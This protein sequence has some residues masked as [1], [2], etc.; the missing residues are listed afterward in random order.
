MRKKR[1]LC[2]MLA[3]AALF[4]FAGCNSEETGLTIDGF[5][6]PEPITAEDTDMTKD[7]ERETM[8]YSSSLMDENLLITHNVLDYGAAANGTKNDGPAIVSAMKAAEQAGGGIVFLPAGDYLV[9]QQLTVPGNVTLCGEWIGNGEGFENGTTLLVNVGRGDNSTSSSS[10]FLRMSAGSMLSRMNIY[11]PGQNAE[12]PVAYPYT[13]ANNAYLGFTVDSVNIINPYRGIRVVNHNVITLNQINMSPIREGMYVDLIYDIPR[14]TRITMSPELWVDYAAAKGAGQ[15]TAI[16]EAVSQVVGMRFGKQDW[17]Y[18]Y[19]C[20]FSGLDTA[21]RLED[22]ENGSGN[23]NGQFYNITMSDVNYG[24]HF[25]SVASVGVSVAYADIDAKVSAVRSETGFHYPAHVF[26]NASELNAGGIAV[27]NAGDGALMFT[28][29]TFENW[30]DYAL[31]NLGMGYVNADTCTFEKDGKIAQIGSSTAASAIVNCTF[32][33]AEP[34]WDNASSSDQVYLR[35]AEVSEKIP[36]LPLEKEYSSERRSAATDMVFFASDF[37]AVADANYLNFNSATDNTEAIQRALNAAGKVGGGIVYLE[38]GDY[39]VKDYLVIP[40]GVELRGVSE[41]NRHFGV[42]KKGTTLVTGCGEGNAEGTPFISMN[43]RAGLRG[44]NVFYLNQHYSYHIAYP[45]AVYVA[46]EGCYIYDVTIPDAYTAVLVTGDDVHIDYL[47][48]LGV[49]ACLVLNGANGAFVE[50]TMITGGDWQDSESQRLLNAP[51]ADLWT[52]HPNYRNEGIYIKDSDRVTL[53]ECFVFGMASG[54]HLVGEV[55]NLVAL[56]LGVDASDNAVLLENKG[57]AVFSNTQLVGNA[58]YIHTTESFEGDASFYMTA[59]WFGSMD[60]RNTF[61]GKG[62]VRIQQY[63]V[64]NGGVDVGT[65][66]TYLQNLAFDLVTFTMLT[67][68]P[69]SE[70]YILNSVG[71]IN[72]LRTEGESENFQMINIGKR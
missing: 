28:E 43:D 49:S 42:N 70:G 4:S 20:D 56:G 2:L 40:E 50:N 69:D 6:I 32:A 53:F 11:Y 13:I 48:G 7:T 21:V 72:V 30:G 1:W 67:V 27:D 24:F 65:A 12:A 15:E 57:K 26:F 68:A 54:L 9:S 29:C 62:T 31:S 5:S 60:V 38:A 35:D 44:L 34:A 3:F 59:G 63:K 33:S 46:G 36:R 71:T 66:K 64:A 37:G 61:N 25:R 14:Y 39:Y 16:R 47:R 18:L 45:P 51:P 52:N 55:D 8:M 58:N 19:D 17:A 10:A 23:F 41:T 22:S